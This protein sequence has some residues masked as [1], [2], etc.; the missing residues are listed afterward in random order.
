M[1][2][3]TPQP[4]IKHRWVPNFSGWI[5][6][7]FCLISELHAAA[8]DAARTQPV[9][10]S[11]TRRR[12]SSSS[13]SSS[14]GSSCWNREVWQTIGSVRDWSCVV[15]NTQT[16]SQLFVN[17]RESLSAAFRPIRIVNHACFSCSVDLAQKWTVH[18]GDWCLRT[19]LLTPSA[20]CHDAIKEDFSRQADNA[21]DRQTAVALMTVHTTRVFVVNELIGIFWHWHLI[22][23]NIFFSFLTLYFSDPCSTLSWRTLAFER[24]LIMAHRIVSY[25]KQ[26]RRLQYELMRVTTHSV[27]GPWGSSA[28]AGRLKT[29]SSTSVSV[30]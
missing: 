24:T 16:S 4:N 7:K 27:T 6:T 3:Y 21:S 30:A 29:A 18:C 26:L 5:T 2:C 17:V 14:R 13:S 25:W 1:L 28:R 23:L 11:D 10:V 15:S 20:A 9:P 19:E 8:R 22:F 12:V